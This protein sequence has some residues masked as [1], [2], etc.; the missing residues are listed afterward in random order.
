MERDF[1]S[2]KDKVELTYNALD[3][4]DG[5]I[6][7]RVIKTEDEDFIYL[8]VTDNNGNNQKIS[9]PI[10]YTKKPNPTF[11][12]VGNSTVYVAYNTT[13]S[14]SGAT[15][16]DGC[17]NTLS[18]K[19]TVSGSVDTKTLG[20]YKI[21]YTLKKETLTRKVIVYNPSNITDN[22]PGEKIIYLTFDDGPG[23]YTQKILDTLAKYN[24]KATF[25]VTHQ[26][27]SYVYLMQKEHEQGHVV[28]AHSYTHN[29]NIYRSVD[30]YLADFNKINDDIERYTGKRSQLFRFPGG[31]SN[32]VSRSYAK[33]VVKAI[34]SRMTQD[35]Y[36]YFDWDVDSTDAAGGSRSSIYNHV[37]SGA[38]WCKKCVVLMHDVKYNTAYELD[39]ILKTLTSKGY[40]F[41]TLNVS[42]PTAHHTIVN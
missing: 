39:N 31:S 40:K 10:T 19:I 21:T 28:A 42:S 29:Y 23:P 32:T 7:D 20:E 18:D 36:I 5:D 4:Y 27:G 12:L 34:A 25:F 17:G 26:N 14:D 38:S 3:N 1:C 15:Y 8:D 41:G 16:K 30:T 11:K 2:K 6:T 24:V 35:G 37:V 13:Y 22:S 9:V 33:G